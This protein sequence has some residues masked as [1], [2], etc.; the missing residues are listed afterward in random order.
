MEQYINTLKDIKNY[1]QDRIKLEKDVMFDREQAKID[2]EA[3]EIAIKK[4]EQTSSANPQLMTGYWIEVDTNEYA[5]SE[6]NHCF[7]IVPEDNSIEEY[8]FCP[9]CKTKMVADQIVNLGF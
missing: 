4:L 7:S 5:C 3:L 9:H 6:C 1:L 2:A 8:K